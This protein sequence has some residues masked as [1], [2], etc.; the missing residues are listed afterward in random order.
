M[1]I[2]KISTLC[3][4]IV[5]VIL[6]VRSNKMSNRR[7]KTITN[8]LSLVLAVI[9]IAGCFTGCGEKWEEVDETSSSGNSTD[10]AVESDG[11]TAEYTA[12]DHVAIEVKD[13]GTIKVALD[14]T[15]APITVENF[16]KLVSSGFYDGLTFHRIISEFMIQ[17][18]DPKGNGTGGSDEN[19][20]GEFSANGVKNNLSH[21]RGAISMARNGYDMDSA[22][23]QFFIVHK[24]S[25]NNLLSLNGQYACFGYVTEGMEVVDK[26][27]EDAKPTDN[28]GTIPKDSQP[29]I[30]K[31]Y[32]EE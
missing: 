16:K 27:C 22:S 24:T 14:A 8:A 4:I 32:I 13:Y 7:F 20:K 9:L 28:N 29:V 21:V 23:S 1:V 3:Y 30:I 10:N 6:L 5:I 2:E 18:G 17:G 25:E 11:F 15:K 31:A 26:I 12:T 19:I